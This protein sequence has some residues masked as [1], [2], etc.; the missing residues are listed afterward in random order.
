MVAD[1]EI[2][3]LEPEC[4]DAGFTVKD[5]DGG[6]GITRTVVESVMLPVS[7]LQLIVK[8][9]SLMIVRPEMV[10]LPPLTDLE[11]DHAPLAVQFDGVFSVFQLSVTLVPGK[12]GPV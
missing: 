4:I 6:L 8:T 9:Y 1:Q 7:L 10:W 12:I 5:T 3:E 11:P 2:V